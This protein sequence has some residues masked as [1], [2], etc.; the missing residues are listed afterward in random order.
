MIG[1]E[2]PYHLYFLL[3]TIRTFANLYTLIAT[4][5]QKKQDNGDYLAS[6]PPPLIDDIAILTIWQQA[7]SNHSG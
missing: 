5:R 1:S 7:I 6:S 3:I 4:L 2:D